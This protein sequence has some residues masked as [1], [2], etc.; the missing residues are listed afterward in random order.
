ML[1]NKKKEL[2]E[3]E[4]KEH[5]FKPQIKNPKLAQFKVNR[6]IDNIGDHLIQMGRKN[7]ENKEKLLTEKQKEETNGCTFKPQIDTMFILNFY[8]A[9]KYFRSQKIMVE[10]SKY[11]ENSEKNQKVHE[12]LYHQHKEKEKEKERNLKIDPEEK[13]FLIFF[14]I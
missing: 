9:H 2:F 12:R 8:F 5:T 1:Q 4:E 3:K 7:R 10:K 11:V 6:N 13:L 14:C